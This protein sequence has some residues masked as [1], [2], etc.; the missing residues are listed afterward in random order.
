MTQEYLESWAMV[1][2]CIDRVDV[3]QYT[4][5]V[6]LE[7]VAARARVLLNAE[8]RLHFQYKNHPRV[9]EFFGK[10]A[11]FSVSAISLVQNHIHLNTYWTNL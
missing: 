11:T 7:I 6:G 3:D 2:T 10:I 9:T 8:A 1:G 4:M 5:E